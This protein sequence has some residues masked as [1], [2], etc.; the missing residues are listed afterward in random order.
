MNNLRYNS[1]YQMQDIFDWLYQRSLHNAT[2]GLNLY[3]IITSENNI[4]LA[5]RV[6]KSNS[7][8]ITAGSDGQTIENLKNINNQVFVKSIKSRLYDYKP[9]KIRNVEIPKSNGKTRV[10]GI[11]IILDRIIQQMFKQVLEPLCEAK[12]YKHSYGF[13]PNRS[14]RHALARCAFI[15]NRTDCHYVVDIDIKG[16]FDEVNHTKL[17]KQLYTIGIKDK[18]VLK[19]ISK[20]LK[21]PTV[22]NSKI[23]KGTPQGGI[24]SPLLSN[25]VLNDLDWWIASQWDTFNSDHQYTGNNKNTALKKT[26]L[27]QMYIVRYADDFKVF[28]N[29]YE[30]ASRIFCAVKQYLKD[31]LKL[32]I[33]PEKSKITNLRKK[34]TDFLGFDLKANKKRKA[35]VAHTYVNKVRKKKIKENIKNLIK[36]IQKS[37][38]QKTINRYN[39]YILGVHNYYKYATH[40]HIDFSKMAYECMHML[41]KRLKRIARCEIPRSPPDTYQRLYPG[42][43]RTYE[44]NNVFLFPI[45]NVRWHKTPNF[46]PGICD[47]TDTG[48]EH[49]QKWVQPKV[50][51]EMQKLLLKSLSNNIEYFDNRISKYSMQNGKCAVTGEFLLAENVHCHHIIPRNM[52]GT[53]TF[54]NLVIIHPWIHI[55]VHATL[56]D[57]IDRYK[58]VLKLS[59]RELEK[60]NKLRNVCKLPNI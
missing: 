31:N 1:Y 21:S 52:G 9:G 43:Y 36:D 35:V 7:G 13:R 23:T 3:D 26:K 8:S 29:S 46:S 33:S 40:V 60:V 50:Y 54:N 56:P 19:V 12:F 38:T 53:D 55:L 37:P 11:P 49:R 2:R 30:N 14:T 59:A 22:A 32:E 47:Y 5:Y 48:R 39:Y 27:K 42:N 20:M 57:T 25:V 6:V 15:I 24:L 16:F 10:L 17:I 18:R 34:K 28:T 58:K 45:G 44:I 4:L 51:F 41:K